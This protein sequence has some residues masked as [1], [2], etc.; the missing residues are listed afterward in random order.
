M[1]NNL[2]LGVI[3][4]LLN[5]T[6]TNLYSQ[7]AVST[8]DKLTEK[9]WNFVFPSDPGFS[10]INTY[11]K[12]ILTTTLRYNNT[13]TKMPYPFYLS[14]KADTT[15]NDSNVGKIEEGKYII[16]LNKKAKSIGVFEII[17]LTNTSLVL[18]NLENKSILNFSAK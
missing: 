14:D 1:K 4:I 7:N 12:E 2:I 11:T 9:E 8:L 6:N 16:T 18:K 13:D 15:F 10:S 5:F 3:V 17:T